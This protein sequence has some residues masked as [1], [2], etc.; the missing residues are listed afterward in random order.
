MVLYFRV[1]LGDETPNALGGE[2]LIPDTLTHWESSSGGVGPPLV[3]HRSQQQ[4]Y[5][6]PPSF[7]V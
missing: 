2:E 7:F 5:E 6:S 1:A 3:L 4:L